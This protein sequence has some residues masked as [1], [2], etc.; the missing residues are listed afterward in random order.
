M[1]EQ[2]NDIMAATVTL[3]LIGLG[4]Y[5]LTN[6]AELEL[7]GILAESTAKLVGW[8]FVGYGL[9]R[10]WLVYRRIVRRRNDE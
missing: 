4:V 5:L 8:L 3:I 6:A 10:G 2:L 7:R 9:L 1:N